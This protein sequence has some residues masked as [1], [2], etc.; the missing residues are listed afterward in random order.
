MQLDDRSWSLRSVVVGKSISRFDSALIWLP[1]RTASRTRARCCNAR[2]VR[3]SES[4]VDCMLHCRSV[5]VEIGVGSLV[6]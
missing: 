4:Y 3:N 1:A 6:M 2:A 5:E